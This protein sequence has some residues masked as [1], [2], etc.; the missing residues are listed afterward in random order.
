MFEYCSLQAE[1]SF[2][3]I[4]DGDTENGLQ[5][6]AHLADVL[7]MLVDARTVQGYTS[8]NDFAQQVLGFNEVEKDQIFAHF[9]ENGFGQYIPE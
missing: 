6:L 8:I 1:R 3:L 4:E 5:F 7:Q 2:K 9:Q